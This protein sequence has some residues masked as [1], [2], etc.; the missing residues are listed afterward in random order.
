VW[1]GKAAKIQC[2]A[3]EPLHGGLEKPLCEAVKVKPDRFGNF[4]MLE[5]PMT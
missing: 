3:G 2:M 1:L 4:K 5:M